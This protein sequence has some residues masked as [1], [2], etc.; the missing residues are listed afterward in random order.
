[1][2][3][4]P[5]EIDGLHLTSMSY[6]LELDSVCISLSSGI[7]ALV[8]ADSREVE[9]VGSVDGGI[10]ALEWSPDGDVLAMMTGS[11]TVL[12]MS[13]EWEALSEIPLLSTG[14]G[15]TDCS[16][17]WRGDGKFFATGLTESG[18]RWGMGSSICMRNS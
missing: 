2:E 1:M 8:H 12:I 16:I 4:F 9:E 11:G 5:L 6:Q 7:I 13:Q 17:S 14:A 10:L 3:A 18:S 15:A